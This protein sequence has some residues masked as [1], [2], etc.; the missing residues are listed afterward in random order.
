ML[1]NLYK[2]RLL[3]TVLC[4]LIAMNFPL[5]LL[6]SRNT[7]IVGIPLL[8]IYL[9][10]VWLIMIVSV[11]W[12]INQLHKQDADDNSLRGQDAE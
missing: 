12:L 6:A 2:K 11:R 9:F 4:A 8:Y 7:L 10:G 3:V 5:L 1:R